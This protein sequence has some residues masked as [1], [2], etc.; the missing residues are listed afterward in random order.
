MLEGT[1]LIRDGPTAETGPS[2]CEHR[3]GPEDNLT[4]EEVRDQLQRIL[5]S[6]DFEASE[7][8]KRFR[9]IVDEALASRADRLKSYAIAIGSTFAKDPRGA[10]GRHRAPEGLI[11]RFTKRL[12]K[13]KLE[14]PAA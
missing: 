11:D 14:D 7:R 1:T 2:A 12:R 3:R 10:C 4:P 6:G 13:A 8:R 9:Q 5:A